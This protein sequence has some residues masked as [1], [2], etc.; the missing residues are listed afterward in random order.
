MPAKAPASMDQA[1]TWIK[2]MLGALAQPD[3][4]GFSRSA[5]SPTAKLVSAQRLDKDG[6]Q[7]SDDDVKRGK[8]NGRVVLRMKCEEGMA[9]QLGSMHG[10]ELQL[11]VLVRLELEL[12]Q[13]L[14]MP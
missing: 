3:S 4:P 7:A 14:S 2:D 10:G 5:I 12:I 9:N 13:T 8:F 6:Q 1:T 11:L